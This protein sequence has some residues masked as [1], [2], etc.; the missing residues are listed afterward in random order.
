MTPVIPLLF[1]WY[2]RF[3]LTRVLLF[4][5]D[6]SGLKRAVADGMAINLPMTALRWILA[7]GFTTGIGGPVARLFMLCIPVF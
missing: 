5:F 7:K 4:S 1:K 3:L 6:L 2:L